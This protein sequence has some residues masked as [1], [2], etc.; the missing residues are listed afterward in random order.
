MKL[1]GLQENLG[2]ERI[3]ANDITKAAVWF[4][5]SLMNESG[6]EDTQG[7]RLRMGILMDSFTWIRS[8]VVHEKAV[9]GAE[10][11][12]SGKY[13]LSFGKDKSIRVHDPEIF[14]TTLEKPTTTC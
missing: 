5:A 3:R 4:A 10:W 9:Q 8:Y 13:Y 12:P 14:P 11:S 7:K 1:A 6:I 2:F